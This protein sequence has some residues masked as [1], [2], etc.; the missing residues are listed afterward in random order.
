MNAFLELY[1]KSGKKKFDKIF[2]K[3]LERSDEVTT[4][5]LIQNILLESKKTDKTQP[6]EDGIKYQDVFFKVFDNAGIFIKKQKRLRV[7]MKNKFLKKESSLN[8][9]KK[10]KRAQLKNL[11]TC[12]I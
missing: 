6:L 7:K 1:P 9:I 2:L 3:A 4:P 5:H 8:T 10:K 11:L 12:N